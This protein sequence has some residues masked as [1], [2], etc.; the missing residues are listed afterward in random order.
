MQ[1]SRRL[2]WNS[3]VIW[4]MR[5]LRLFPELLLLPFIIHR[6]GEG[7]YGIYI[8][9][10][11]I[12]PV[13]DLLQMGMG[14]GV[15]KYSA[16]FFEQGE[17]E[18]VNRTLSTSCLLSSMLGFFS[19]VIVIIAANMI[20]GWIENI[21]GE[22]SDALRFAC[23]IIA[24][25]MIAT[26]PLMPYSGILHSLQRYDI[27]FVV[28]VIFV[29][30]R[31]G[32]IV[33]WYL[34]V[35]PSFEVLIII[36]AAS[37]FLSTLCLMFVA[38]RLVPGLR[39]RLGLCDISTVRL[40]LGFGTV[41][42]LCAVCAV[43]NESGVRWMMGGLISPAFV[44]VMAIM[45]KPPELMK[46]VVQ[47]MSLS[48]MPAT[49]KYSARNDTKMLRELFVRGTRYMMLVVTIGMIAVI[50]MTRGVLKVW[51]GQEY[52]YLTIYVIILC[53]AMAV[54][55]STSGVAHML[56]GMGMLKACFTC[57]VVGPVLLAI[58]SILAIFWITGQGYWA[59]T[60]G[61]SFGQIVSAIMRIG[62]CAAKTKVKPVY[63]LWH[64][65]GQTLVLAAPLAVSAFAGTRYFAADSLG[66]R[67]GIFAVCILVF[68]V[69][70][71]VLFSTEGEIQLTKRIVNSACLRIFGRGYIKT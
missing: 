61:L 32:L 4:T 24:I 48:V 42:F 53:G 55:M 18:K 9:A 19:G 21:G 70:F 71:A 44:G 47:A 64:A 11:S 17:I 2:I 60:I 39:N 52:Q 35:E 63:F 46:Q 50:L 14:S 26:F 3:L 6:L 54:Q 49:S 68:A 5:V 12:V 38:Y 8:L 56:Q 20:P 45:L 65:Y 66:I 22:T 34:L 15:V 37:Y 7:L 23:N 62:F 57:A 29:Y 67:T 1:Q 16:E 59:V 40:I 43:I 36:S 69:L 10:W 58:S 25:M 31:V 28:K 27:F 13:F 51:I 30:L 41:I 33:C